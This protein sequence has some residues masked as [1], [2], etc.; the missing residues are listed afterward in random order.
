MIEKFFGKNPNL[1]SQT[2]HGLSEVRLAE[3]RPLYYA[4]MPEIE[5]E[6][7]IDDHEVA[8]AKNQ[9]SYLYEQFPDKVRACEGK[10]L[11]EAR[12]ELTAL[13][14]SPAEAEAA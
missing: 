9:L 12:A 11:Q 10:T 3:G 8:E 13:L 4:L 7:V 14:E 6:A 2:E 1:R 5:D